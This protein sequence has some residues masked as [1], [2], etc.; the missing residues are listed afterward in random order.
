MTEPVWLSRPM[1]DAIHQEQLWEHG[2]QPGV[3]DDNAVESA[4]ARPR[5][6]WAYEPESDL[7]TLAAAYGYGL[8]R[9]HGY[10][11]GNKGVAFMAM[12]VSGRAGGQEVVP[13]C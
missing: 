3:K 8:A 6:K 9:N 5:N 10:L 4:I 12:Y 2:G 1:V 13:F 11:D 7:A